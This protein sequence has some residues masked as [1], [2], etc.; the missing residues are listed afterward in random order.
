VERIE[1]GK[2]KHHLGIWITILSIPVSFIL[3]YRISTTN[4]HPYIQRSIIFFWLAMVYWWIV[5]FHARWIGK[6]FQKYDKDYSWEIGHIM[7]NFH[8]I[9]VKFVKKSQI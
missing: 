7:H 9:L 4:W 8:I 3:G 2:M 6:A 1:Q 5:Y